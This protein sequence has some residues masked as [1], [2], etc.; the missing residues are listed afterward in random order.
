MVL[1]GL[2]M[3]PSAPALP[4]PGPPG[5]LTVQLDGR[6]VG[7]VRAST[8]PAMVAHLRAIKAAQLARQQP[9]LTP[10]GGPCCL[11]PHA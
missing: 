5:H 2:G 3:T 7:S 1:A 8:A 6:V 4:A 9:Q 11:L 10:G